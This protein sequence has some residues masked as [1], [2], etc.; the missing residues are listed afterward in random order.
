ML[1]ERESFLRAIFDTP[2]DTTPR[3]VYA[4]W[5]EEHNEETTANLIRSWCIDAKFHLVEACQREG[6]SLASMTSLALAKSTTTI[7]VSVD[8]LL[9]EPA[10]RERSVLHHPEWFGATRLKV[11]EG[12]IFNSKVFDTIRNS[13]ATRR[14][15]S[16][17]LAGIEHVV[18]RPE[19]AEEIEGFPDQAGYEF[20]IKSTIGTGGVELLAR[21]KLA[22]RLVE[23]DLTNN[24]LGNDAARALATS[25]YLEGLTSLAVGDGNR[26]RG[27]VWQLLVARF[28]QDVLGETGMES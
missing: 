1:A 23:L 12:L 15:S 13:P 3:L 9:D 8:E 18:T 10:F 19:V 5:L 28:G 27:K 26:I 2:G 4:D 22:R 20:T 14:I 6:R 21:H 16:L 25:P 24:G 7:A 11:I 17:S